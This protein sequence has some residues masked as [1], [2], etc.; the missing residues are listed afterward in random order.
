MSSCTAYLDSSSSS[1]LITAVPIA[2][3]ITISGRSL[4]RLIQQPRAPISIP[5]I[6]AY[7][8]H[9]SNQPSK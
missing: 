1:I 5:S 6:P 7:T 3:S 4:L 9:S 2:S 8:S